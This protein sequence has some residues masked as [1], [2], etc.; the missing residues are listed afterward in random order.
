MW[1]TPWAPGRIPST[2]DAATQAGQR[3][4]LARSPSLCRDSLGQQET[5]RGSSP[6]QERHPD[7]EVTV[8]LG[9]GPRPPHAQLCTRQGVFFPEL[10]QTDRPRGNWCGG[11]GS[12]EP[13]ITGRGDRGRLRGFWTGMCTLQKTH[14]TLDQASRLPAS[15]GGTRRLHCL[16]EEGEDG[17]APGG[18]AGY[19]QTG[20]GA[21]PY[22]DMQQG[23]AL[24]S[25]NDTPR[26][27]LSH[28]AR[29]GNAH[30]GRNPAKT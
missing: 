19:S 22:M 11:V 8:S 14:K 25:V 6:S 10:G 27:H 28:L 30:P 2:P 9:S 26:C 7:S 24:F 13:T 15:G 20:L 4:P 29:H 18:G 1:G 23:A 17:L 3:P 5:T 12:R 21:K 16:G